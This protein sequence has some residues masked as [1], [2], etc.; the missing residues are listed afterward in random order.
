M[1]T[2]IWLEFNIHVEKG[3]HIKNGKT[4]TEHIIALTLFIKIMPSLRMLFSRYKNFTLLKK[5][6][7]ALSF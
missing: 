2:L 1:I 7:P 6:S 3:K 4:H 5:L